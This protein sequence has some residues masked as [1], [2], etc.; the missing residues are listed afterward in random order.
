MT[1][2]HDHL[3]IVILAGGS[4]T[5][6]WPLSRE[7]YPK[8]FLRVL[9]EKSMF[10]LTLER[11]MMLV[12]E[13]RILVVT[14]RTQTEAIT[15]ELRDQGLNRVTVLAEP[16]ARNTAAAI[17]LAAFHLHRED[18]H[19][20]MA[21]FPSDHFIDDSRRFAGII[22]AGVALAREGW[23]V[24]FGIAPTG[25]ET[26]YGYIRRGGGLNHGAGDNPPEAFKAAQFVE[27][28]DRERARA[29]VAAG[30]YLWN[31]G[32]FAWRADAFMG[33][34]KRLLPDHYETLRTITSRNNHGETVSRADLYGGLTSIS[35]DYG[36]LEK[37]DRVA[38]VPADVGWSDVGSWSAL[39]ALS[40]RDRSDNALQGDVIAVDT[41]SSMVLS[42]DRLVA[43]LGME[44][45]VVVETPDAILVSTLE[46]S[47]EV[48]RVCEHLK[49]Q[50]RPELQ[51]PASVKKPWG[52]YR[53]LGGAE[54]FKVK[55]IQVAPG[56]R[57]SLQS[58]AHRAE[59]WIV[60]RGIATVTLDGEELAVAA[61]GHAFIPKGSRH[62]IE[63]KGDEPVTLVEVQVGDLLDETDIVR[64]EDDYGRS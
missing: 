4:G 41:R 5:R 11:A 48:R 2:M 25:P 32:I 20:V 7:T 59:H 24:T 46:R 39:H 17:G 26:G 3:S 15:G 18:P 6:F 1:T 42:S 40:P 43:V 12:P 10:A 57:L 51:V 53:V 37:S 34:M 36:I 62:R 63:N 14:V 35:V 54:G 30:T 21:V 45:T 38:I 55:T 52:S 22:E 9:G 29:Y 8:Q 27:K 31:S 56:E 49:E 64:Y 19:A 61:G 58:H 13:E 33:E 23:L 28:P 44:N 47:Q 50:G 60:T 16:S